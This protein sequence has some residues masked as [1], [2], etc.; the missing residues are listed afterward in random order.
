MR[1]GR[2]PA[3]SPPPACGANHPPCF[4]KL[5]YT[6]LAVRPAASP[7]APLQQPTN[8]SP[9]CHQRSA[10]FCAT[11]GSLQKRARVAPPALSGRTRP[12]ESRTGWSALQAGRGGAALL[13]AQKSGQLPGES[14]N[15]AGRKQQQAGISIMMACTAGQSICPA[16]PEKFQR[17]AGAGLQNLA[18]LVGWGRRS[19]HGGVR[20]QVSKTHARD[21]R[22]I[23]DNLRRQASKLQYTRPAGCYPKDSKGLKV[24]GEGSCKVASC[25]LQGCKS[26]GGRGLCCSGPWVQHGAPHALLLPPP[27]A[28]H[29]STLRQRAAGGRARAGTGG[30]RRRA[31]T[32]PRV[33]TGAPADGVQAAPEGLIKAVLLRP[34]RPDQTQ[35]APGL[36]SARQPSFSSNQAWPATPGLL[37]PVRAQ[38]DFR[39]SAAL[40]NQPVA[41]RRRCRRRCRCRR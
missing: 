40:P 12:L 21:G 25:R 8:L 34:L 4:S 18:D 22:V 7:S 16:V 6:R 13:L 1:L 30:M 17:R 15:W 5:Q 39:V 35:F 38:C 37:R 9:S 11:P 29:L 20:R 19:G 10:V 23:W 31:P 32:L 33:H 3:A 36:D 41:C 27:P 24:P 2:A 28:L 14:L 26:A